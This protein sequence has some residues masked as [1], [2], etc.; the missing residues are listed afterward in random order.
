MLVGFGG[1]ILIEFP[2]YQ[3]ELL[4][5]SAEINDFLL[6]LCY[7]RVHNFVEILEVVM[8]AVVLKLF[9]DF[10]SLRLVQFKIELEPNF[11]QF[12]TQLPY[13]VI[14]LTLLVTE[15]C[16]ILLK[17]EMNGLKLFLLSLHDF[18]DVSIG[19][20]VIELPIE[21]LIQSLKPSF[22]L[23]FVHKLIQVFP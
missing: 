6:K 9:P 2:N 8:S 14:L 18:S 11:R 16:N 15:F 13:L 23:F 17:L 12:F 19:R 4:D 20:S 7:F 21:V 10:L 22:N 3:L 1:E 5:F